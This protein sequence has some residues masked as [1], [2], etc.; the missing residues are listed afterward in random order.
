M[1]FKRRRVPPGLAPPLAD[2]ERVVAWAR[3]TEHAAVVATNLGMFLPGRAARLGWHEVHKAVWTGRQLVVTPAEL[4]EQ[5]DGYDVVADAAPLT[6]TLP[7]QGELPHVVRTR[8]TSSVSFS[9]H[10][11]VPGGGVRLV[12]RQVPGIDGLR[13]AARYD[14]GTDPFAPEVRD[15]TAQLVASFA[16]SVHDP[17]L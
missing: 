5:R 6:V 3:V 1:I 17:S 9:S 11:R 8:V 10:Q 15:A 14:E 2:D 4:V 16:A 7:E 12:A 13:W